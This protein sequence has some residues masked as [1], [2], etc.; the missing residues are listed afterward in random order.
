MVKVMYNLLY[1]QIVVQLCVTLTELECDYILA[2]FGGTSEEAASSSASGNGGN[3]RSSSARFGIH[4][5]CAQLGKA[6]ALVLNQTNRLSHL[7]RDSIPSTSSSSST[8]TSAGAGA[9]GSSSSSSTIGADAAAS[10]AGAAGGSGSG[11]STSEVN[12]KSMELQ[13]QSLCLPFLRIAAL[14][15]QHL[16]RHEMPEIS[17]PGLE[18]VRLVYYLELVT[19]SMDWDCFNASKG[20][21]FIPGTEQTLPQFWCQQLMDV[22]PPTD[23]VRELVLMNQHSLWQQ[24][25][26]LELPRE[27]ERLFTVRVMPARCSWLALSNP[28]PFHLQYYHERPCLNCY[29]VPKESSIC[30][31]CGTIVCLK[32]NCCAE[33]ECCEAVRVSHNIHIQLYSVNL[34]K[35]ISF[36]LIAHTLVRRRHWHLSGGHLNV[37]HCHTRPACLPMGLALSGRL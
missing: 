3:R 34:Y 25:R 32:Q 26:L 37:H 11:A 4:Q 15:R 24:P 21:C 17:A 33:K 35:Y 7:R 10:A 22:R 8:S 9:S 20:L 1:Y 28:I 5:N 16:Y 30:L 6:M 18:F 19:D 12:L 29:K 36:F 27:Y 23:T 31:L 2:H 13:L 14:L